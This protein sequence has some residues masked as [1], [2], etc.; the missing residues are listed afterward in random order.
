MA[1]VTTATAPA[2][3]SKP[4]STE[5]AV[6]NTA[7]Q[8]TTQLVALKQRYNVLT[9]FAQIGGLAPQHSIFTTVITIDPN[10]T[11]GDVYDGLKDDGRQGLEYLKPGEVALA[12]NGLRKVAEGLGISIV[13]ME[14]LAIGIPNY[15]HVQVKAAYRGVDGAWVLREAGC[16]W[17]L[18]DGSHRMRGWRPNQIAEQR[19][20]GLRQCET[21]A[22]NAAIRECGCGVKQSYTKAELVKPFVAFRVNF[23]PDMSHEATRLLVTERALLGA[24]ALFAQ[25]THTAPATAQPTDEPFDDAPPNGVIDIGGASTVSAAKPATAP[26]PPIKTEGPPT[27]DAVRIVGVESKPW[28]KGGRKGVRFLIT[29]SNGGTFSTLDKQHFAD[30]ERFKESREW[31]EIITETNNGYTNILEIVKAGSEPGLPGLDEV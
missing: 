12:K 30:A 10:P 6:I 14:H 23:V 4:M 15:W 9:P 25:Q 28:E 7:E 8:Y 24:A 31:V 5:L 2:E 16:E 22:I 27:A 17:D 19:K 18:R 3:R 29:D 26:P 13:K 20:N 11:S 21:R 1:A